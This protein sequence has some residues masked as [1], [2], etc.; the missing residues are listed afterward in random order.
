MIHPEP[1]VRNSVFVIVLLVVSIVIGVIASLL[2]R[3]EPV[4]LRWAV[5]DQP[6]VVGELLEDNQRARR[7]TSNG[8]PVA[9]PGN[10]VTFAFR[11]CG[12]VSTVEALSTRNWIVRGDEEEFLG[13]EGQTVAVDINETNG[14]NI[15]DLT[16]TIPREVVNSTVGANAMIELRFSIVPTDERLGPIFIETEPFILWN[17]ELPNQATETVDLDYQEG[18]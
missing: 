4:D 9:S 17:P 6:V 1:A 12:P 16:Y 8:I 7:M 5:W 2:V 13:F 10:E 11:R 3:H 15:F 14:C 18:N